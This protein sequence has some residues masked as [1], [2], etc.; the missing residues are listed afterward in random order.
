[1][2]TLKR[3]LIASTTLISAFIIL[4][5]SQT[6]SHDFEDLETQ[7]IAESSEKKIKKLQ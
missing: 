2:E 5:I 6:Y 1:M 4:G 3:I 7:I